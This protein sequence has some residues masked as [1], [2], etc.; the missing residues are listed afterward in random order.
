MPAQSALYYFDPNTDHP[1][2]HSSNQTVAKI[3]CIAKWNVDSR[4][5]EDE[6]RRQ[7][8]RARDWMGERC[9][10]HVNAVV[11]D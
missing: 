11:H 6:L 4:H 5:I 10:L 2:P 7:H 1:I 9:H 3:E 8:V